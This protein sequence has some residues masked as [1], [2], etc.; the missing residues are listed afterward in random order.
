VGAEASVMGSIAGSDSDTGSRTGAGDVSNEGGV[1]GSGSGEAGLSINALDGA[2][3][4][5]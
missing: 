3:V 2:V 5:E 4:G 1:C